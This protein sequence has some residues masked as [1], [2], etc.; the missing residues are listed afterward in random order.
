MARVPVAIIGMGVMG[1]LHAQ[2]LATSQLAQLVAVADTDPSALRTAEQDF[3]VRGYQDYRELLCHPDLQAVFVCTPE[4]LHCAPTV[5]A[6]DAGKH[7]FVEKPLATSLDDAHQILAAA[8]RSQAIVTVGHI[9]RF[10]PRYALAYSRI[11]EG[12]VGEVVS[13]YARRN[14]PRRT[15]L[16]VGQRTSLLLYLGV[17]DLDLMRWYA[18]SDVVRVQAECSTTLQ[19]SSDVDCLYAL[20]KF[21]SGAVGCLE[22][23]WVWPDSLGSLLDARCDVV[24]TRGAVS[25]TVYDQGLRIHTDSEVYWPDTTLWPLVHGRVSGALR[26]QD[27]HFLQCVQ[28]GAPPLVT[29]ED[30]YAAV[31]TA[32]A[33]DA[34]VKQARPVL[35]DAV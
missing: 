9:L 29:V 24:G 35:L 27:E 15:A 32:L 11:N 34:A 23:N 13:L 5:A 18:G 12:Q 14:N 26:E 19:V 20:L 3:S 8:R 17:H 22:L 7:V 30:G 31:R 1:R 16:H 2:V 21:A 10:E 6:L 4:S 33:I 25:I 28:Q